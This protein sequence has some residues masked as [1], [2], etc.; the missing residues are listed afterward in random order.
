M[1]P[2]NEINIRSQTSEFFSFFSKVSLG[3]DIAYNE[4]DPQIGKELSFFSMLSFQINDNFNLTPSLRYSRLKKINISEN[5][6]KGYIARLSGR[7]QFTKS[8]SFRLISE[9]NDFQ[10]KLL[11]QPLFQWNPNPFTIFYIGGNQNALREEINDEFGSLYMD[12][13]Q[14]FIKFQYLIGL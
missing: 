10:K 2:K 7:Y 1:L 8:I 12:N 3:K 6:F 9:Y 14:F 4:D 5:Y 11:I 13:S